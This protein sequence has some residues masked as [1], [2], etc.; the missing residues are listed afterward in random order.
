MKTSVKITANE[1]GQIISVSRNPEYGYIRVQQE[2]EVVENNFFVQKKVS[3]L[4]H[5][6]LELLKSKNFYEG[7]TIEGQIVMKESLQPID[8]KNEDRFI[9]LSGKNGI[10]CTVN[11][12]YIY[13]TT[14]FT[15]DM[16]DKDVLIEHDN[17]EE[18]KMHNAKINA[19]EETF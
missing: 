1:T 6:R 19:E 9:K 15:Q 3:A 10:P 16:D 2:K 7:Q 14:Y 12:E 4:I 5:G 13:S 17:S 18:I 11:G 8:P